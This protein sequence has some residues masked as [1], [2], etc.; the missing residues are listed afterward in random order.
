MVAPSAGPPRAQPGAPGRAA[1]A[2]GPP[3][4]PVGHRPALDEVARFLGGL[5]PVTVV[6][7]PSEKAFDLSVV[8]PVEDMA[9]IE[10]RSRPGRVGGA[11]ERLIWP[12]I[13]ER[14]V[15]LIWGHRSTIVFANPRRLAERLC[16]NL[17]ELAGTELAWA[18]TA[19]SAAS[20]APRSRR[21]RR[22]PACPRWSRPAPGA[23]HRHG[24][25]RPG[26]SRWRRPARSRRACSASAGPAT[27]WARSAAASSSP[28]SARTW[29]SAVVVERM[30]P[31]R[32][33]PCATRKSRTCS[34]SRSWPW[35]P[36]TTGRSTTS[37]RWSAGPP[38]S[39]SCPAAPSQRPRHAVGPLPSD[40]FAE[41]RPGSTGTGSRA[42]W[43]AAP[44]PSAWPSPPAGPSPT[45]ACSASSWSGARHPGRRAG[46]GD[47]LR[48]PGRQVYLG[49]SA[50]R[51]DITHDRCWS[52]RLPASRAS[53][54]SG[55]A[56]CWAARSSWAAPSARSCASCRA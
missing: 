22:W 18:T 49:A 50:W 48:V 9:T 47:G 37:R 8:V 19:R 24:R 23:G 16:A 34:P 28:S 20:S 44:A 26:R 17:N 11:A 41:L 13:D 14:L 29:S 5:G 55:T 30:R 33:R 15:E 1:G 54:R 40:E 10:L 53:C 21:T 38:F 43:P 12:H 4:R 6:A 3:H 36:W 51:I 56:T 32:S 27:R 52:P 42:G 25:R 31:G 46:R 45:G 7:P 2:A 39:P 35:S